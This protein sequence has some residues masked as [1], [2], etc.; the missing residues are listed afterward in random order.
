MGWGT[1][2]A[3]WVSSRGADGSLA[4]ALHRFSLLPLQHSS[5]SGSRESG[6]E[7]SECPEWP[8]SHPPSPVTS[9]C[10]RK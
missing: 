7:Q 2:T 10:K 3:G 4:F 6:Y 8:S 1:G 9:L 5:V